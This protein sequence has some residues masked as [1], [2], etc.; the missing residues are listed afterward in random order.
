MRSLLR[1]A[2]LAVVLTLPCVAGAVVFRVDAG[3][4]PGGS[5]SW[6]RPFRT[7]AEARDA[8]RAGRASGAITT[9]EPVTVKI[10]AGEYRLDE[11]F[12]LDR[13]DGG[14][15]DAS[16][17][18]RGA[19]AD[20]TFITGA[21]RL[22]PVASRAEASGLVRVPVANL[23]CAAFSVDASGVPSAPWLY[24]DERPFVLA[25]WPNEGW[26]TFTNAVDNGLAITNSPDPAFRVRHPGAFVF[27]GTRPAGWDFA[28]GVWL[29]GYWTHDW[30]CRTLRAAAYD[31]TN[32]VIR[33][34]EVS[35]YGVGVKTWGNKFRRFRS[36]NVR[37]ELDV[38][39]EWYLD[40]GTGTVEFIQP[41]TKSDPRHVVYRLA[42]L[43]GPLVTVKGA[44]SIVFKDISFG[45]TH[46]DGVRFA[47]TED[48]A[49]IRCRI[50]DCARTGV[51]VLGRR[52]VVRGCHLFHIGTCGISLAG[53]DR[54]L[55]VAGS[56]VVEDCEISD[57]AR[58]QRTYA[59]GVAVSGCG[60][61]VRHC[62]IHDAPHCAILYNGNE[63]LI[64]SNEVCRVVTE[65][66]DA[67]AFYTGR[68]WASQGNVV[69]WNFIHDLGG[70]DVPS[71]MT[72]GVY[73]DDCDCGDTIVS[74]RFLR[75][76]RAIMV[77]GGRS[78]TVVGNRVED[79]AIGL[80]VDARGMTWPQW[81]DPKH[82]W[83]L[84]A[85]A[86]A[87]GYTNALWAARY[88]DLARIMSDS[89]REPLHNLIVSNSFIRCAR[90]YD[91]DANV[92]KL[93]AAGLLDVSSNTVITV[94]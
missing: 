82:G 38:P 41:P 42:V 92:K 6:W 51:F 14:S 89:P 76:G 36:V 62:F 48:C 1:S 27:A 13:R 26:A 19:G 93:I 10:A 68:D 3:A 7:L 75:A 69:R 17:V 50:F 16:I 31:A 73:L 8:I 46:G 87:L 12:L 24:A 60:Q 25:R 70:S 84:E 30:D 53:G 52:N 28:A 18:Y 58:F 85:A 74:N 22:P 72:M 80:H 56:N 57:F 15:A 81:N 78:N 47:E 23:R 40:R 67:G 21:L 2:A 91:L 90:A 34:A 54:R 65:T 83:G 71:D 64:E 11:T 94:R 45:W 66:G 61:V 43:T 9:N 88:P 29:T 20:R 39:G 4:R 32:R 33:L 5:G 79:C 55:L 86:L 35:P 37:S 59:P 44:R 63:H 49:L 77:G